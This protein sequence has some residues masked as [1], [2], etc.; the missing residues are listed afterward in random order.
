V[1]VHLDA[2]IKNEASAT[3]A[4]R[5]WDGQMMLFGST[6]VGSEPGPPPGLPS[7]DVYVTTREKRTGKN[8]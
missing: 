7:N 5:S 4:S 2:P 1:P 6:S 8:R 3:G